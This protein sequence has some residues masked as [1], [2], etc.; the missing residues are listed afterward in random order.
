M[1]HGLA[2]FKFKISKYG[3]SLKNLL[4]AGYEVYRELRIALLF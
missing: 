2:N 1:I 4:S 3:S